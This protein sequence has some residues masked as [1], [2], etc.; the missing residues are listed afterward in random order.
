MTASTPLYR[1]L[2]EHVQ[3]FRV[4]WYVQDVWLLCKEPH[5]CLLST[6]ER[7]CASSAR[8]PLSNSK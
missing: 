7:Q 1:L 2:F 6:D 8:A 5:F 3:L 4:A